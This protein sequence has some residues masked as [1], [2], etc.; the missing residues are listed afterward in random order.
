MLVLKEVDALTRGSRVVYENYGKI[1][2]ANTFLNAYTIVANKNKIYL[3]KEASKRQ[4]NC[5]VMKK[6]EKLCPDILLVLILK[7]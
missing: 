2:E 1:N 3:K 7:C 4:K 6:I 5:L